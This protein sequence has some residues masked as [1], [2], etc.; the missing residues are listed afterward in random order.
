MRRTTNKDDKEGREAVWGQW[1]GLTL[2]KRGSNHVQK[3]L[4]HETVCRK[5]R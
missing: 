1:E 2:I 5:D 3:G 4:G